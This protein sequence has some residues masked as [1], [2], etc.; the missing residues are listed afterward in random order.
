MWMVWWQPTAAAR[1]SQL[2]VA[3]PPSTGTADGH[4][5]R[6][7]RRENPGSRWLLAPPS[8]RDPRYRGRTR[9][10]RR[11]SYPAQD[12]L[13]LAMLARTSYHGS[14]RHPTAWL[15]T[16]REVLFIPGMWNCDTPHLNPTRAIDRTF[17]DK[18]SLSLAITRKDPYSVVGDVSSAVT[19]INRNVNCAE[20]DVKSGMRLY[21][22][23]RLLRTIGDEVLQVS[24]DR[25]PCHG[26]PLKACVE[27]ASECLR[28]SMVQRGQESYHELG[29]FARAAPSR[30]E[31][32][33]P[34][35]EDRPCFAA[36]TVFGPATITCRACHTH[37][38][39]RRENHFPTPAH[40]Q[41][42]IATIAI[43]DSHATIYALARSADR[44]SVKRTSATSVGPMPRRI[45]RRVGQT[46]S[47]QLNP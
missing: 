36:R 25:R 31:R 22:F 44:T 16:Q 37:Q 33:I 47:P 35:N 17:A 13:Q 46:R 2:A 5:G 28:V 15:R 12:E 45:M 7:R 43:A 39:H 34:R 30:C 29:H 32:I 10:D 19:P 20:P 11:A 41:V 6:S 40:A 18:L 21:V 8:R 27:E 9:P 1:G 26:K 3:G 4:G 38:D 24:L 23:D 42:P 14:D